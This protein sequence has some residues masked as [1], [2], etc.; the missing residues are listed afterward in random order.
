MR[1]SE[2]APYRHLSISIANNAIK[3]PAS[4]LLDVVLWTRHLDR[5]TQIAHPI[6]TNAV[7]MRQQS[8]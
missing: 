2:T 4:L 8:D 6:S 1:N 3:M 5:S 7:P